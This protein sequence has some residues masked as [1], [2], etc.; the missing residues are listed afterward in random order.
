MIG[1]SALIC[2]CSVMP[3]ASAQQSACEDNQVWK[4]FRELAEVRAED[5]RKK[6]EEYMKSLTLEEMIGAAR[7]A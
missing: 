3:P 4:R 1:L 6:L 2:M 5:G 7:C